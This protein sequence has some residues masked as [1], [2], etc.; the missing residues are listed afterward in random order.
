[1]TWTAFAILAMF[2]DCNGSYKKEFL[3]LY[4]KIGFEPEIYSLWRRYMTVKTVSCL[5]LDGFGQ[6]IEIGITRHF[7]TKLMKMIFF[8]PESFYEILTYGGSPM[9][10][11]FVTTYW[12]AQFYQFM[13]FHR[14]FVKPEKDWS[15]FFSIVCSL[16]TKSS[17]SFEWMFQGGRSCAKARRAF[18]E[19]FGLGWTF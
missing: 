4:I 1:M 12:I 5:F 14:K 7:E 17:K 2:W 8:S 18:A 11:R 3:Q 13:Y 16:L 15:N 6:H 10:W 9:I 19:K